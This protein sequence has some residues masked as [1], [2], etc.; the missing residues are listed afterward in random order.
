[1]TPPARAIAAAPAV[2]ALISGTPRPALEEEYGRLEEKLE[3]LYWP[4]AGSAARVAAVAATMKVRTAGVAK[5]AAP[6]IF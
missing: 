2:V 1:M 4:Y 6:A 3:E 5:A